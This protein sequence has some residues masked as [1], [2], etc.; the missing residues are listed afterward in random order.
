MGGGLLQLRHGA[1]DIF[2]TGQPEMSFFKSVENT[3]ILQLN[4]L[5]KPYQLL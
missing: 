1:Q 4:Q 3:Q 2:L 5:N